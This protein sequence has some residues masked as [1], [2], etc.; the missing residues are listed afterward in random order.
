MADPPIAVAARSV[1]VDL[2]TNVA[3]LQEAAATSGF[4]GG[5]AGDGQ[6]SEADP[7]IAAAASAAIVDGRVDID[8]AVVEKVAGIATIEV[9]GVFDLSGN[10]R[11]AFETLGEH[12]H[13]GR[14]RT[15]NHGAGNDSAIDHGAI[16]HGANNHGAIDHGAGVRARSEGR[17]VWIETTIVV[18]HDAMVME[19]SRAVKANVARA[20]SRT[21]GLRVIEV[22]VT[23]SDVAEP[24]QARRARHAPQGELPRPAR[25][26]SGR[27]ARLTAGP[28]P[29]PRAALALA[30]GPREAPRLPQ[31]AWGAI[32]TWTRSAAVMISAEAP[33][34]STPFF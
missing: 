11:R 1:L 22:N 32:Q 21:L 27:H 4:A 13:V 17:D 6:A 9:P 29:A 3:Y 15:S 24:R 8:D 34:A 5:F 14:R 30:L 2:R 16:D 20:V 31:A 19:V 26:D 10:I 25:S 12:I 33:S 18:E 28:G 7:P 23:V